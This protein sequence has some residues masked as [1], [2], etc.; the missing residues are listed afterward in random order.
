M[1]KT[2][3]TATFANAIS[4]QQGSRDSDADQHGTESARISFVCR[5]QMNAAPVGGYIGG[6]AKGDFGQPSLGQRRR[7]SWSQPNH[8]VAAWR[9]VHRHDDV[10][11]LCAVAS[12]IET[13]RKHAGNSELLNPARFGFG[14][15]R[16]A[17]RGGI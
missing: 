16:S 17:D 4:K 15:Q 3:R 11:W 14:A 5:F 12:D 1:R 6:D 13:A 7:Y 8:V 10:D 2:A 9:V